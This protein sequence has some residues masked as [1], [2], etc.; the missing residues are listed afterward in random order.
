MIAAT[1]AERCIPIP[2]PVTRHQRPAART[3]M[4]A[5]IDAERCTP[6]SDSVTR[7]QRPA[8]RTLMIATIDAE[9]C[10]PTPDSVTRHQQPAARTLMIAT[11]DAERCTP[12]PDP[13]TQQPAATTRSSGQAVLNRSWSQYRPVDPTSEC[14][15]PSSLRDDGLVTIAAGAGFTK[16]PHPPA[17]ISYL[18]TISLLRQPSSL[19]DDDAVTR[20]LAARCGPAT[21]RK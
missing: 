1:D 13:I 10:T 2:D 18:A 21:K 19:R 4:I 20:L 16:S 15:I 14:P 17:L 9:R 6:T 3:L 12:I 11:T 8:A 7:H 5:T